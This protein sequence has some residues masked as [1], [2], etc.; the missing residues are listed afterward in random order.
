[1][2]V[3]GTIAAA[4]EVDQ[5]SFAGQAGQII[6]LAVASTGGFSGSPGS[7]LSLE[8]TLVS[9][10]GTAL[11]MLR[12]NSQGNFHLPQTGTYVVRLGARNRTT[13]GSYNVN[14]ECLIPTPAP[15]A[16]PL[17]C[18]GQRSGT[19]SAAAQVN[20]YVRRAGATHHFCGPRQHR[21]VL[22]EPRQ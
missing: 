17:A 19:V 6:S 2:L 15:P 14:M 8:L 5:Y 11:G 12:S 1:M 21:R 7:S 13:V 16:I 3:S 4:G 9:P 20:L 18:G 22:R 10:A